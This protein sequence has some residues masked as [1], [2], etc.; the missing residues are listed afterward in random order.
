MKPSEIEVTVL[1]GTAV[2]RPRRHLR[3]QSRGQG[4]RARRRHQ[5]RPELRRT[6]VVMFER[7]HKPEARKV[8]KQL[9]I[10]KLRA[11]ELPKSKSASAGADVAV[12]SAR[13]MPRRR[14]SASARRAVVFALLV[15]ATVAAFA[16]AQRV[17]RD[18]LVLDR[19]TFVAAPSLHPEQPG[20]QL[21][22]QRRLP[23]RP[24][25]DP[26]PRHQVRRRARCR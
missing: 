7:G 8:A 16:W 11:D 21:H 25:P 23:L 15:L 20:P 3:R 19:V 6:S 22:P 2:R 24:D 9:G 1:N 14:V 5:H 10:S 26:L 13:T 12:W 17:K 4:L 18:P